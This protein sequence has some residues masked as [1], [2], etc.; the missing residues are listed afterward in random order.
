MASKKTDFEM[1]RLMG[2]VKRYAFP[3]L[4]GSPGEEKA[5]QMCMEDFR[6]LGYTP[7]LETFKFSK[8][9][10]DF[11]VK[12]SLGILAT[13]IFVVVISDWIPQAFWLVPVFAT[14]MGV[15]L[16]FLLIQVRDPAQIKF[17]KLVESGNVYAKNPSRLTCRGIVIISAHYDSKSQRL[18]MIARVVLSMS[19]VIVTALVFIAMSWVYFD[20]WRGEQ[21]LPFQDWFV[22]VVGI[23]DICILVPLAL[24]KTGNESP[25]AIDNATGMAVVFELARWF[26]DHPADH[27]E[28]WF[29]QFGAEEYGTMGSRAFLKEHASEL[30]LGSFQVRGH[31]PHTFDINLDMVDKHIQYLKGVGPRAQ[32][33]APHLDE[34]VE[35][36]SETLK[37]PLKS[38]FLLAGAA[39]DGLN[40]WKKQIEA[41]DFV[42]RSGSWVTHTERDTP[43]KVEPEALVEACELVQGIVSKIDAGDLDF[44]DNPDLKERKKT[45]NL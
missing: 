39:V 42:D 34:P 32:E 31:G 30:K 38:F 41:V 40:F 25:G 7:I 10:A 18:S 43:D 44:D 1:N 35:T 21:I 6:K 22:R 24:N 8:F 14:G 3:R 26:R 13:F 28:L 9:F 16:L 33:T 45:G 5:R 36:V 27:F 11:I 20:L 2:W 12:G 29:V 4:V 15:Y 19:A 37:I 23:I 17:G